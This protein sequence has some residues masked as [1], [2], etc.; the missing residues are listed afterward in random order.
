MLVG[1]I[2]NYSGQGIDWEAE[3]HW[4]RRKRKRKEAP[5]TAAIDVGSVSFRGN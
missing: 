4:V 2:R 5:M 3:R 1:H